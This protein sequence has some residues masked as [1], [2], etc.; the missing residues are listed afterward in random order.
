MALILCCVYSASSWAKIGKANP[1]DI[2]LPDLRVSIPDLFQI[3]MR[4]R[5]WLRLWRDGKTDAARQ[6]FVD[7]HRM[8]REQGIPNLISFAVVLLREGDLAYYRK[9]IQAAKELY[10]RAIEFAP[11]VSEAYFHLFWANFRLQPLEVHR[12][13]HLL[14]DGWKR[15]FS[16]PLELG[17]WAIK[18]VHFVASVLGLAFMMLL[19]CLLIRCMRSIN[20]DVKELLPRGVSS[21]QVYILLVILL[22]LPLLLGAGILETALFWLLFTWF[23]QARSE[24]ILVTSA[25]LLVSVLPYLAEYTGKLASSIDA[26]VSW[27][28]FINR[29]DKREQVVGRLRKLLDSRPNDVEILWTL[30]LYHK[31]RSDIESARQYYRRALKVQQLSELYINLGNLEFIERNAEAAYAYYI[32]GLKIKS[33]AEGQYN[34]SLLFK[35]SHSTD[36]N[37]VKQSAEALERARLS[38]SGRVEQFEK[39]AELQ[40]NRYL[41]DIEPS[42]NVYWQQILQQPDR[43]NLAAWL[44]TEL[45]RW[46]PLSY[47]PWLGIGFALL[48]W[49]LL[50]LGRTYLRGNPCSKCGDITCENET[51]DPNQSRCIKCSQLT[52]K[53]ENIPSARFLERE[54]A[55]IKYQRKIYYLRVFSSMLCMGTGHIMLKK[56]WKGFGLFCSLACVLYIWI[57]PGPSIAIPFLPVTGASMLPS[58]FVTMVILILYLDSLKEILNHKT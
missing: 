10:T 36:P 28:Y 14:W 6:I 9:D 15:K 48:L 39:Q 20:R 57:L 11:D 53:K 21:I 7:I 42:L 17:A 50:P 31:R 49:L 56:A 1:L 19:I 44:W 30:G 41:M 47:A 46:I 18:F 26:P 2:Q 23:Y 52:D 16:S 13:I 22:C 8:Q 58:A 35:H 38:G 55:I 29:S 34:L 32:K 24:R 27:L 3:E 54:F 33:R 5:E 25:L 51:N 45:C 4:V 43:A 12:I 40:I 37:I